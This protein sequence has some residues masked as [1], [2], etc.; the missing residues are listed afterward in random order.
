MSASS[1]FST[2]SFA[3]TL[4]A[5][6]TSDTLTGLY[7]DTY[8]WR[9]RATDDL[10]NLSPNSIVRGFLVDT[11]I[12]AVTLLLPAAG[13]ETNAATPVV[14]WSALA[15]SVGIDTYDVAVSKTSAFTTLVFSDSVDGLLTSDTITGLYNDTYFWR[16]RAIDD[17]GNVGAVSAANGFILDTQV[18]KVTLSGPASGTNT[19]DTTPTLTWIAIS[20]SVGI[21]SYVVE[22]TSS[23]TFATT[24]FADTVDAAATTD[25]INPGLTSAT[26]Y[27]RVR[28][29]DDLANVGANSDSFTIVIDTGVASVS[30]VSPADG[31]E[32]NV[33][34]FA[35][36]WS[37]TNTDTFTW[38][39]AASSAFS[40]I[41]DSVV[42]TTATSVVK[43][44]PSQDTY[45]WRVI[46]KNALGGMDTT[47]ARRVTLDT[48]IA[49]VTAASPANGHE[50]TSTQVVVSWSAVS[51]STGIDSYVVE[52][53]SS[54]AFLSVVFADTVD[55]LR[56]SD[57]ATGLY[58]DTYFWRVRAIDQVGNVG[59]NSAAR[60][61]LVD[62]GVAVVSLLLPVDAHETTV[63]SVQMTWSAL[64]DS[65]GIDSYV[66][67]VSASS[68]FASF[69]FAD[70]VDVIRTADT[71]TALTPDTYYWRVRAIDDLGNVG[72]NSTA[73]RFTTDTAYS[74]PI[75]YVN[76]AWS[77]AADSFTAG[78]GS[79]TSF[80][81]GSK[82]RPFRTITFAMTKVKSGETV[83]VD[84]GLY[85]ETVVID[86]DN[87]SLVGKDSNATVIDPPGDSSVSTL[88][89][90]YASG[91]ARL[92]IKDLGVTGAY[93]GI[94]LDGVTQS[95]LSGDSAGFNGQSGFYLQ[96]GSDT[97][98]VTASRADFNSSYGILVAGSLNNTIQNNMASGS[99]FAGIYLLSSAKNNTISGNSVSANLQYGI[100]LVSGS[101]NNTL[102]G[103]RATANSL[104][105]IYL[106]AG[107]NIIR[108]N[109]IGSNI[110]AGI[111]IFNADTI[112][113]FQNDITGND[114]GILIRGTSRN[115]IVAKNNFLANAV[116][117]VYTQSGL[118]QSIGRNWYGTA[119]ESLILAKF[120]D[121]PSSFKPYRLALVDTAA[122]ADTTAPASP[123]A[124]TL[125]T[126][127]GGVITIRWT[128]P[129]LN[130][131]TNG[132]SVG[133]AGVSVYRIKNRVDTEHWANALV[134]TAGASDTSWRDTTV[135]SDDTYYY[136]LT[137]RDA[138]SFI[139]E[140]FF[141]DTIF[142]LIIPPPPSPSE[143]IS[144]ISGDQQLGRVSTALSAGLRVRVTDTGGTLG[145]QYAKVVFTVTHGSGATLGTA[146]ATTTTLHTD[147]NGYVSETL[148]LGSNAGVYRVEARTD[149]G[150]TRKSTVVFTAYADGRDLPA[151]G[152][153]AGLGWRMMGPNKAVSGWNFK[154]STG[155]FA[156]A[157]V[158]EWRADQANVSSLNNSKYYAPSGDAVR[159]RAYWVKD[160]T[161]GRAFVPTEGVGTLDTVS[162]RLSVGWNQ[163]ASGQYVYISWDSNVAFDSSGVS[164]TPLA[165]TDRFTP[166]V[167]AD[168]SHGIIQNKAYWYT[169][170]NYIFGPA[171]ETNSLVTM[172][173]KPM[174]GFW[175][176]VLKSCT[177][178]IYPNPV[179]PD[180]TATEILNQ[181]PGLRPVY[182]TLS[183]AYHDMGKTGGDQDW[184]IQIVAGAGGVTD[185]Q[186][187]I[188][189]KSSADQRI[190]HNA[191]EAP[192]LA[193]GYLTLAVRESQKT[194]AQDA[195]TAT[196][197]DHWMAAAYSSPITTGR[198]WDVRL[199]T[200]LGGAATLTWDNVASVPD[201]YEVYLI[202][203]P[204]GP[205]N[206]RAAASAVIPV[207]GPALA[208]SALTLAVGQADYLAAFLSGSLSKDQT[209]VYP[210]PGPD[211]AGNMNF[212]F[213]LSGTADV[214]IR[215]YDVSG[216]MMKEI[217]TLGNAGSNTAPW[218]ATNTF[219][220]KLG[221]GVYIYIIEGAGTKLVDKL[222]IVR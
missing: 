60:G 180:T 171:S 169:G 96:L 34:T 11:Q 114:T 121:T 103:N 5:A 32:T 115:N 135:T 191:M 134:W 128:N 217:K 213:N 76:D 186:N 120:N 148:V 130:E 112:Q 189:V 71:V 203:G 31:H 204:N 22:V 9:V 187:Y 4:D 195:A 149:S 192:G 42:D 25:T 43:T 30:L 27:W 68:G 48:L 221:S 13:H 162:I 118:A 66:V 123:G 185:W 87:F 16:V 91:R 52:V 100:G 3:D 97:N 146:S 198:T 2:T 182:P 63:T 61:F 38:Q 179:S 207:A 210:N 136:R 147:V 157:T 200:D 158:Y 137:G 196:K 117:H 126:S 59:A 184:G 85:A 64:S 14:T 154:N 178:Y 183:A 36:V 41:T 153:S 190:A 209:F 170:S 21:D 19:S 177:M 214:S 67:E 86:T 8:F 219:G 155:G 88:Y 73:R 84:A 92:V 129:A 62:T 108:N 119:N 143:T 106:S 101:T 72:A 109:H 125:D 37:A 122:G 54:S 160:A 81:A 7:N 131:E 138:V 152:S 141:T 220:Q 94:R 197:S 74:G 53:S 174:V 168:T 127:S 194:S 166:A 12:G 173:L 93:D 24:S 51:D 107:S 124:V 110:K 46:G 6:V 132:G 164:D 26:Y 199:S 33:A 215:I 208:G 150:S 35:F 188:G 83:L 218:D 193:A 98:T 18:N 69:F 140:S 75:W 102:T 20:D 161:G 205:V 175:L 176:Y 133:F 1:A 165:Q 144:L 142:A 58:N 65:V 139:N 28:A 40:T 56:T 50:T 49:Q 159:G 78:G 80:G 70:T 113:V 181:A 79:D 99:V 89:A 55:G 10:G 201:Q 172:Q 17:L 163:I 211:A 116:S 15:D 45:Y 145:A 216:R 82:S 57:T 47:A 29:I 105:G 44:V 23:P 222:A 77:A 156:N 90:I 104:N 151:G 39:L 167:A 212:K 111:E 206:L 202:G 95:T